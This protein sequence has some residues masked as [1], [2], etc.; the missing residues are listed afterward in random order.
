MGMRVSGSS[1]GILGEQPTVRTTDLKG[2]DSALERTGLHSLL[3]ALELCA[4][5]RMARV[6]VS[7]ST[8]WAEGTE[9]ALERWVTTGDSWH[10]CTRKQPTERSK[11]TFP[12]S[13]S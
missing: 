10:F 12:S 6:S 3:E 9:K 11:S 7:I 2:P 13:G 4:F 1:P 5:E 8:K